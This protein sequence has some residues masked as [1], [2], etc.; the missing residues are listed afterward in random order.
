MA[1]PGFEPIIQQEKLYVFTVCF[2][3][4]KLKLIYFGFKQGV[5]CLE[6]KNMTICESYEFIRS[7]KNPLLLIQ[8]QDLQS[9][10]LQD[11]GLSSIQNGK[12]EAFFVKASGLQSGLCM[13]QLKLQRQAL[14]SSPCSSL[15]SM[16]CSY[17]HCNMSCSLSC[18]LSCRLVCSLS[19]RLDN[20]VMAR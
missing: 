10:C 7:I 15:C 5:G 20:I 14:Q 17:R 16:L 13:L 19:C 6:S 4:P 3:I 18:S 11:L 9:S 12:Y 8:R 2:F 1:Q